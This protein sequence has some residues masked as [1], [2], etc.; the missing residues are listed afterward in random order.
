MA[1]EEVAVSAGAIEGKRIEGPKMK[2]QNE[3]GK[4]R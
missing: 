4:R 3:R 1:M 2:N